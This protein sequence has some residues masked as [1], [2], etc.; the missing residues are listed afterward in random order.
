MPTWNPNQYLKFAAE[1]TRPCRELASQ[2]S[3]AHARRI[4]DLG[5]GP[6]NST[7]VIASVW[8]DADISALDSSHEM[9]RNGREKYPMFHWVSEDIAGWAVKEADCFD[10]VFSN[11]ALQWVSKHELVVPQ[12]LKHVCSGGALAFQM[13]ADINAPPHKLMREIFG[14][15]VREWHAHDLAYYYDLLSRDASSIVSW[16]TTYM[17]VMESAEEIVEWYKGTGLRPY[18]DAMDSESDKERFLHDYLE[19]IR[20]LYPPR[21]DGRILFPFRRIFVIAYR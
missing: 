20:K 17:H 3:V 6:G 18:I 14:G 10:V 16:E 1:R 5:S 15:A 9:V 2:I 8:P 7:E 4:I 12:L 11:A 19:G 21:V 13:P